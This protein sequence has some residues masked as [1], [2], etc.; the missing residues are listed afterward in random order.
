MKKLLILLLFLPS[1]ASAWGGTGHAIICE[2]AFQE[3]EDDARNEV[4][5]LI[6]LD[7]DFDA[8]SESCSWADRPRKRAPEH[9]LNVPRSQVVITADECPLAERCVLTAIRKDL[10]ILSD[11]SQSDEMRLESLKF[12]GH[13]VGDIH[14]PLH[15][16]YQDDR[17]ANN[18]KTE[19]MC[20]GS[21]HGVWDG[22]LIELVIGS[23]S[24]AIANRL[25]GSVSTTD[26]LPFTVASPTDW[27]N[28]SYQI[29]TLPETGYCFMKQDGC[30]YSAQKRQLQDGEPHRHMR[31]DQD[32]ISLN[33]ETVERRLRQA[34]IRLGMLLNRALN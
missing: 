30:W 6:N 25:R 18:V 32:Y 7:D 26:H 15:V 29:T 14:Q 10:D 5:R 33:R 24:T 3:L 1:I 13:W 11:K 19:G 12:L 20:S 34:G 8:F 28:E 4:I 9:Y 22:C 2:I 16:S 27:A 17:G 31:I 23:N 21:L